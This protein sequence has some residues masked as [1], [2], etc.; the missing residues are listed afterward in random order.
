MLNSEHR[1]DKRIVV[2]RAE[3]ISRQAGAAAASPSHA[4]FDDGEE[5]GAAGFYAMHDG[6]RRELPGGRWF[7][8][9][10][11]PA[12]V[13]EFDFSIARARAARP[14]AVIRFRGFP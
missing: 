8:Y 5:R 3:Q 12:G 9:R 6:L 1:S 2:N 14:L 13:F 11:P 4:R 7:M 10:W